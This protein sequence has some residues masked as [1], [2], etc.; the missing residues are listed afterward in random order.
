MEEKE[1]MAPAVRKNAGRRITRPLQPTSIGER[2][3]KYST[4]IKFHD[5]V[6]VLLNDHS[7]SIRLAQ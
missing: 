2:R 1:N 7:K 5:S 3:L 4:T 6:T